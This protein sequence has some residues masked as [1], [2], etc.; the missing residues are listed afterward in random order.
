MNNKYFIP[1]IKDLY[2]GYESTI[3]HAGEFNS[4]Y[5]K[6]TLDKKD[7]LNFLNFNGDLRNGN[8]YPL[9]F[10]RT[11]YL[12]KE[13][14]EQEGWEFKKVLENYHWFN[15]RDYDLEYFGK[16]EESFFMKIAFHNDYIFQGKIKCV[17]EF[18]KLLK[19]LEI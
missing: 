3:F 13:Q 8:G 6:I 14:I 19:I 10:L 7:L 4:F 11:P 9:D 1:E 2:I 16:Y 18:R 5:K 17:N 15:K 12:T